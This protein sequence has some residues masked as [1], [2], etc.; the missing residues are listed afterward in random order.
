M[1]D[2]IPV[3][4]GHN[5]VLLRLAEQPGGWSSFLEQREDGHLDLPRARR[6]GLVGGLFAIYTPSVDPPMRV[7]LEN[8]YRT[9][10]PAA[11]ELSAA[12]RHTLKLAAGLFRLER[13]SDGA[14]RVCRCVGEIRDAVEKGS[15][16]VVFHIEGAEAI[17]TDLGA[18]EVFHQ[19]GLRSLGPVW[20]R[21]NAFGTGVPFD[22][23][24]EP[25]VGPGLTDAGRELV[26][27][28]NRLGIMVDLSHIN[29]KGFWD[30]ARTSEK[31]LVASHSNVHAI[32]PV[33]RNLTD[34]QLDA[35]RESR[36]LVGVNFA[37]AFL[38]PGGSKYEGLPLEVMVR[39]VDHLVARLGLE[40]VALGSDFDG[41]NIPSAIGDV[42]GLQNLVS[43]LRQH[44]YDDDALRRICYENWLDVLARTWS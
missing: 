1:P 27:A 6:G 44:G 4:D 2:K 22:Y 3:F 14:V 29:E 37:A 24:G 32:C 39:H 13:E 16:A 36:G 38:D 33:P 41:A 26:R 43:A 15:L 18:L 11:P 21:A 9:P 19:A 31:P 5:D 12:Q 7:D 17:D 35:I 10:L 25:D 23:P 8:G 30:V 42:A 28:C 34:R 20:S 40:G